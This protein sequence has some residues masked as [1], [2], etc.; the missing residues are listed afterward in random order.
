[1][2]LK[3]CILSFIAAFAASSFDIHA[4]TDSAFSK[5][6]SLTCDGSAVSIQSTCSANTNGNAPHCTQK[7]TFKTETGADRVV[8]YEP[9]AMPHRDEP[10][11]SQ[12]SCNASGSNHYVV[13]HSG[14]FANCSTCEWI[15]VFGL[16]GDFIGSTSSIGRALKLPRKKLPRRIESS[17]G[18]PLRNETIS[19]SR[20]QSAKQD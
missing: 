1:M 13:A 3:P 5:T 10:F 19:I 17:L 14:N 12:L 15:D 4:Q 20:T 6:D 16:H 11:V 2:K 18:E 9:V 7:L 8:N